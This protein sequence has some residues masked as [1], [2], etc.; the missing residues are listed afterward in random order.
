[1]VT[2]LLAHFTEDAVIQEVTGAQSFLAL[3]LLLSRL[4]HSQFAAQVEMAGPEERSATV[5]WMS[6]SRYSVTLSISKH[7]TAPV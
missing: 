7:G 6:N 4:A 3:P 2:D 5:D 1:M